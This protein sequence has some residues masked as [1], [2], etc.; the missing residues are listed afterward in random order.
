MANKL[1]EQDK[2]VALEACLE[3]DQEV[4]AL[5]AEAALEELNIFDDGMMLY[6]FSDY[7]DDE[8]NDDLIDLFDSST[9]SR[10]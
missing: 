6:D 2:V 5:A 8:N 4:L 3:H 7:S 9:Y 10:N 1:I